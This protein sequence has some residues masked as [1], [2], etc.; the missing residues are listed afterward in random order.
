MLTRLK[1]TRG[2]GDLITLTVQRGEEIFDLEI[3]L[4]PLDNM[5]GY[6]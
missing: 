5:E 4:T 3:A 6:P 2:A 1:V